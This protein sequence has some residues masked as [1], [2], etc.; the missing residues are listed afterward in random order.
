MNPT[1]LL[2]KFAIYL[3]VSSV[4]FA[5]DWP[6]WRGM[7]RDGI[8]RETNLLKEWPEEGP[9]LIWSF[10]GLGAGYS[11]V[12]VSKSV[13]FTTGEI[14]A[15]EA[16][17]AL[18]INGNLLWKTTYGP[19]WKDSYQAMR[20]TPTIDGDNIYVVSGMGKVVCLERKTGNIVWSANPVEQ[21][22]AEYHRWGIA[23]SPLIIDDM[24]ICSPGGE[25]ASVVAYHKLTGKLIWQSHGLSDVASFCSPILVERGGKKIIV[26]TLSETFV[27][28]DA[29]N[30]RTLWKDTFNDY[31]DDPKDINPVS[32]VYY[33]GSIYTTSGYDD[34]G[35]LYD[36][37]EDG[38]SISRRWADE[39][40]D[41]H[42]GGVVL[43]DGYIYGANW[44]SNSKGNWVCLEWKTGKVMYEEKWMNKGSIIFADGLL[45]CYTEKKGEVGLVRPTPDKF[46]LVS[47]FKIP[48][49]SG[50]RWA[51]PAISDGRLYIRR[52]EALM[53]FD[54][55]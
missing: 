17:F 45:Y 13:I 35:A 32:P 20:S 9:K 24:V 2:F 51:H 1:K 42:I 5:D 15:N 44:L 18:D 43:V 22:S 41:V 6:Q 47:H 40:L 12:A 14:D 34:G 16:V 52:G 53:V 25:N 29:S 27:G 48:L 26:T 11:S 54:I 55:K 19:R 3:A 23:D 8:S 36:L 38:L 39:T 33:N 7:N 31:Q 49:G 46:S 21:F 50:Q 30:G 37:S 4:V 28:I 10:E